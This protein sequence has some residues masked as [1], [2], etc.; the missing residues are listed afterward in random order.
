MPTMTR[1]SVVLSAAAAGI[2]FG[3][4]KYVEIIPPAFAQDSGSPLNPKGQKFFKFKVGDIEV[5]QVFDG[6]V[7]RDHDP[8]FVK[9]ASLD[10]LKAS[11]KA[12]KLPDEKLLIPFTITVVKIGER[13]IMFDSGNG[14][15]GA[16]GTGKLAE[17]LKEAGIDPA[18]LSTIVVTH[19]HPDHIFGLMTKENGQIYAG[20]EIIVPESEYKF[21]TDPALIAKLPEG[22]R[23][24][25]QR[26]QATMPTWKNI[27]QATAG[28]EVVPGVHA[29]LTPGHTPGHTSFL[30]ASGG[31]QLFVLGDVTNLPAYNMINPGW[32]LVFDQ[33][34]PLAEKTRRETFDRAIAEKLICTGY[35]WGMPGAG[36]VAKDGNGYALVPVA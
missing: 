13:T 29:V 31:K 22:R 18:K 10:D 9:N 21:W 26:I 17:N 1:R 32:H 8:G 27:K 23:G 36:T 12:A 3:L 7:A 6:L 19:F 11:M 20:T 24:L 30:M 15:G 25:A 2:A 4:S 35:H 34:A 33:D 5:T 16:P 28:K 14:T